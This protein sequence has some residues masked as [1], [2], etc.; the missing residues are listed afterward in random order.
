MYEVVLMDRNLKIEDAYNNFIIYDMNLDYLPKELFNK[1]KLAKQEQRHQD[2]INS[3]VKT[4]LENNIDI[5][6]ISKITKISIE[7]LKK[8]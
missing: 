1:C 3:M 2:E 6:L 4:M 7:D 5:E 8:L